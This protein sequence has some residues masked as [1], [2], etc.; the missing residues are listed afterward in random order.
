MKQKEQQTIEFRLNI[1]Q[2]FLVL[3]LLC[4]I[5]YIVGSVLSDLLANGCF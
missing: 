3:V 2:I 4:T 1:F 5:A